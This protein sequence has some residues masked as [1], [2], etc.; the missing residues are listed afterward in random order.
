MIALASPLGT[1]GVKLHRT[2]PTAKI[3]SCCFTVPLQMKLTNHFGNPNKRSCGAFTWHFMHDA[4]RPAEVTV[5]PPALTV[6]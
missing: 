5:L 2:S 3:G 4:T 6:P 1:P